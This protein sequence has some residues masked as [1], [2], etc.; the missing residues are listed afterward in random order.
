MVIMSPIAGRRSYKI[1][2]R[3]LASLGMGII[4]IGLIIFA[5]ITAETSLY[6]IILGLAN[7]G[8]ELDYFQLPTQMLLWDQ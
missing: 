8:T 3:K 2:P 7:L 4:T 5:L 1:E 6:L